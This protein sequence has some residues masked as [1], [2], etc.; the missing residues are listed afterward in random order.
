ML[1]KKERNSELGFSKVKEQEEGPGIIVR[2]SIENCIQTRK[3][4]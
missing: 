3:A 4:S 2:N 1:E